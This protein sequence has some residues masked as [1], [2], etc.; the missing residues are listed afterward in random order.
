LIRL[1]VVAFFGCL[2]LMD[3]VSHAGRLY[4]QP[5]CVTYRYEGLRQTHIVCDDGSTYTF[6]DGDK[7][8]GPR[9][10][11]FRPAQRREECHPK[12]KRW[13]RC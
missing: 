12:D 13:P 4:R 7:G 11:M 1:F 8:L 9:F 2:A 6:K 3:G 5:S 10:E